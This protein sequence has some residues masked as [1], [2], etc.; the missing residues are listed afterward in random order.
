MYTPIAKGTKETITIVG[1]DYVCQLPPVGYGKH[2]L[3]GELKYVGV[4][5]VSTTKSLQV[6]KPL[7]LPDDWNDKRKKELA[8]QKADADY[9]DLELEKVRE[10]WWLH[11]LC[12]EWVMINGKSTF[13]PPSFW[14]YI[15][16]CPLDVGL[17]KYR[18]TDKKFYYVWE[19]CL[20]DPNC[21]G[22]VDIERRR[23]GKTYKAGSISLDRTTIFSNH[24][25]GI[26]SKTGHDAKQFF[27]KTVINFFKKSPDFFRP[28]Y[29]QSKGVT[30]TSELRFFKTVV[31]GKRAEEV[32]EGDELESW[33]DWASSECMGPVE[34]GKVLFGTRWRLVW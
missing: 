16:C 14:F 5:S 31:K 34:C 4:R 9:Y 20:E 7:L 30:P 18:D 32:L 26:Q 33:C 10:K 22:L 1:F 17:P 28:V 2:R 8:R 6:W 19:Y 23:M 11:R 21:G 25:S 27:L 29:D 13:I 24:H 3:T 15:N 12:G